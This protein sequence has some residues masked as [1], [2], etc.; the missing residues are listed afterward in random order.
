MC[1]AIRSVN[2]EPP[3]SHA[4]A[5]SRASASVKNDLIGTKGVVMTLTSAARL[6]GY[7]AFNSGLPCIAPSMG[8]DDL[9]AMWCVG[10]N[11]AADAAS[12]MTTPAGD[13]SPD[14]GMKRVPDRLPPA[15]FEDF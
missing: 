8:R 5:V 1:P 6:A 14:D 3:Q 12:G 13:L 10:W 4:G 7:T 11:D 9:E 2:V 15:H